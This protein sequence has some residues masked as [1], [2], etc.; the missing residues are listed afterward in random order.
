MKTLG[1]LA[2]LLPGS[3]FALAF[4]ISTSS[5]AAQRLDLLKRR[6]L[7]SQ[8]IPIQGNR[9]KVAFFDADETL[10]HTK[11][12]KVAP[13]GPEDVALKFFFGFEN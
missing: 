12:G 13:D 4:A 9:V 1:R 8:S 5:L 7:L 11:S 3:I 2:L 6:H 10:R